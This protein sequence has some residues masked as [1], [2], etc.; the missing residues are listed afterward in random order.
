MQGTE[1][2]AKV[3]RTREAPSGRDGR[4]R[5]VGQRRISEILAA[6][7]DRRRRIQPATVRPSSWKSWCRERKDT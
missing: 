3:A 5:T 6:V 7:L 2:S 1:C 4:D